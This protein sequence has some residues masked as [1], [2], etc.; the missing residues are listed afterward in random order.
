MSRKQ[1]KDFRDLRSFFPSEK[2]KLEEP[3]PIEDKKVEVLDTKPDDAID[4]EY[5]SSVERE[6]VP[7]SGKVRCKKAVNKKPLTITKDI[8][9]KRLSYVL[10]SLEETKDVN[11]E[12]SDDSKML[13][14]NLVIHAFINYDQVVEY[15]KRKY[16]GN[17]PDVTD[18]RGQIGINRDHIYEWLKT[19]FPQ[20]WRASINSMAPHISRIYSSIEVNGKRRKENLGLIKI[21]DIK[22][23]S[24]HYWVSPSFKTLTV[25][26]VKRLMSERDDAILI[27][28]VFSEVEEL[29][30]EPKESKPIEEDKPVQE[31]K[32]EIKEE[33]IKEDKSTQEPKEEPKPKE[34]K[35]YK[36]LILKDKVISKVKNRD[37]TPEEKKTINEKMENEE[38]LIDKGIDLNSKILELISGRKLKINISIEVDLEEK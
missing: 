28:E 19:N 5:K 26:K 20:S 24:R 17:I 1:I 15:V 4:V 37:R 3:K 12:I 6:P 33:P 21:L 25:G 8:K 27:P 30:E 18:D 23:H 31:P 14:I 29:V 7:V 11:I 10:R 32:E 34:E 35:K 16:P 36:P 13:Q 2:K 9:S 38:E 22:G